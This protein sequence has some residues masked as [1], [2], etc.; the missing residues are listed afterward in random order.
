MTPR[1]HRG[2]QK[3]RGAND[4][5]LPPAKPAPAHLREPRQISGQLQTDAYKKVTIYNITQNNTGR[6]REKDFQW[7]GT[8]T[9]REVGKA[10]D[11]SPSPWPTPDEGISPS[12]AEC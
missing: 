7:A 1:D 3:G 10:K 12:E 11:V 8:R 9:L 6:V 5:V 4:C 2:D